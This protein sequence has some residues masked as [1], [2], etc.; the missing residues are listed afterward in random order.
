MREGGGAADD[1]IAPGGI[2][3]AV[4]EGRDREVPAPVDDV[5]PE[6]AALPPS[7]VAGVGPQ[8]QHKAQHPAGHLER[9]DLDIQVGQLGVEV[10]GRDREGE[11]A[12]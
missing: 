6:P 1:L 12:E 5:A 7:L 11:E 10:D 3:R 4:A 9:R 2:V 8:D